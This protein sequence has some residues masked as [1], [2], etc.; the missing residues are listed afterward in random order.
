MFLSTSGAFPSNPRVKDGSNLPWG[1]I[2]VPFVK[3]GSD[4]SGTRVVWYEEETSR[5]GS[6]GAYAASICRT[7]NFG[8][9]C[10]ICGSPHDTPSPRPEFGTSEC[11][12]DFCRRQEHSQSSSNAKLKA[13]GYIF[14]VDLSSGSADF[15]E[16]A[17][18]AISCSPSAI[19]PGSS[20][21]IVLWDG[22]HVG[23]LDLRSS[24]TPSYLRFS[25][26]AFS[27]DESASLLR[28]SMMVVPHDKAE[29]WDDPITN[30]LGCLVDHVT[31]SSTREN[32]CKI[33]LDALR[34]PVNALSLFAGG[35]I[36]LM[37]SS[38]DVACSTQ[39]EDVRS[40]AI[41]AAHEGIS[42]DLFAVGREHVALY[43]LFELTSGRLFTMMM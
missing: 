2:V 36:S 23:A 19:A 3:D 14:F 28:K 1:A 4:S 10:A 11:A 21:G 34:A 13:V 20:V 37:L 25:P 24:S 43:P 40:L 17:H 12:Q 22:S 8:W 9:F 27:A 26:T 42:V 31:S 39:D 5:C 38:S 32:R 33:S 7:T 35:Q 41:G 30:A 29:G 16:L 6:C 15:V 18:A